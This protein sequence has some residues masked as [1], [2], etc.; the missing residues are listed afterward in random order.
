MASCIAHALSLVRDVA[1]PCV[2]L[3][4]PCRVTGRQE[5][6]RARM[7]YMRPTARRGR[8]VRRAHRARSAARPARSRAPRQGA[9]GISTGRT[10]YIQRRLQRWSQPNIRWYLLIGFFVCRGLPAGALVLFFVLSSNQ[11]SKPFTS[12]SEYLPNFRGGSSPR[13]TLCRHTLQAKR[14][15]IARRHHA[16]HHLRR[17]LWVR[18]YWTVRFGRAR[19]GSVDASSYHGRLRV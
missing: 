14:H 8:G 4:C 5:H 16:V 17:G 15:I 1:G 3:P 12:E 10:G 13:G 6:G 11:F 7:W 19:R 18:C 9:K 2:A